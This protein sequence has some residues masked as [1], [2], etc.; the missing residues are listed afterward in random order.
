M[1]FAHYAEGVDHIITSR[2]CK[3]SPFHSLSNEVNA[4]ILCDGPSL[5]NSFETN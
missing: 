4:T 3:V 2:C 5:F 1:R